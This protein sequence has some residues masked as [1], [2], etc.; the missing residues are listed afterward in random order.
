L[1]V[2]VARK[3]PGGIGD[4]LRETINAKITMDDGRL[5]VRRS[6]FASFGPF[7]FIHQNKPR[8]GFFTGHSCD[9]FVVG[10]NDCFGVV[11]FQCQSPQ[12]FHQHP[13]T[14]AQSPFFAVATRARVDANPVP[15]H[16]NVLLFPGLQSRA[17]TEGKDGRNTNKELSGMKTSKKQQCVAVPFFL[18]NR[19]DL[20]KHPTFGMQQTFFVRQHGLNVVVA[21]SLVAGLTAGITPNVTHVIVRG[22]RHRS[23]LFF[24]TIQMTVLLMAQH[25][26]GGG[27]PILRNGVAFSGQSIF[28]ILTR[29]NVAGARE[30][31]RVSFRSGP[32][33]QTVPVGD[34]SIERGF[35]SRRAAP[36]LTNQRR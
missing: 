16:V 4:F 9:Q 2:I 32:C 23:M 15:V 27:I 33:A 19:F 18:L 21:A 8:S 25:T 13:I 31:Q 1:F 6:W 30:F 36:I 11:H 29:G 10:G 34:A 17:Q 28:P 12:F 7:Q 24:Q 22:P 14:V 3:I 20:F 35:R 5:V 26:K